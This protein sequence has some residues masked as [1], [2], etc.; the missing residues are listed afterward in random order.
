MDYFPNGEGVN[1]FC[2][3][4]LPIIRIRIPDVSFVICGARPTAAVRKLANEPGVVVT[5]RVPDVRSHM[6]QA[7]VGVVPLRIARGI[8]NKLL[9]GMAMGLPIVTTTAAH[10][11]V[12]AVEGRDLLVADRPEDFAAAVVRL[13]GEERVRMEMGRSAREF[14]E[15]HYAWDS[16]LAQLDRILENVTLG[17]TA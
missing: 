13:L 1:W 14:M 7:S 10:L 17:T 9:E 4:V 5:G 11:G 6:S 16:Q 12:E 2:R 3:E 15:S 8:Q